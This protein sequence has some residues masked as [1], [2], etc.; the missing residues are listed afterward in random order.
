[1]CHLTFLSNPP[2]EKSLY[3]EYY[4]DLAREA[5][6]EQG[7]INGQRV[8]IVK[9]FC[10]EGTLLDVGCGQGF[11]LREAARAGYI[12]Q[13]IDVSRRAVEFA[14]GSVG[15]HAEQVT[16][17]VLLA[18]G[19]RFDIITLWHVLEHVLSPVEELKKVRQLLAPGGWCL[20]EV[21]N[22]NSLK[23]IFAN[24]KWVGG[25]HPLY[26]RTF[27]TRSTLEDTLAKSGFTNV[28]RLPVSYSV[29]GQS[30]LYRQLK[31]I[32]NVIAADAFLDFAAQK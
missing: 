11:F 14:A 23:F 22:L 15:V 1:V 30:V 17:D 10:Q 29:P 4:S 8:A 9:G 21:P 12:A 26:H 25:N 5:S 32:S 16:L 3:D 13:G 2:D 19:T 20:V 31:R 24:P 27:F 7:A 6:P 28:R 18:R